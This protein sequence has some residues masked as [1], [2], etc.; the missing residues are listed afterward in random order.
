MKQERVAFIALPGKGG[1]GEPMTSRLGPTIVF[2]EQAVS[3]VHGLCSCG[4]QSSSGGGLLPVK[5]V[6]E[7]ESGLYIFKGAVSLVILLCDR[8]T[9]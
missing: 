4:W 9:V 1:H 5:T 6:W 8:I 7:C 3:P 2:Q